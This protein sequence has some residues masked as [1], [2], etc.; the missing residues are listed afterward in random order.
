MTPEMRAKARGFMSMCKQM[1]ADGASYR[2]MEEMLENDVED[3]KT[4]GMA[5]SMGE[6]WGHQKQ[7]DDY[8]DLWSYGHL[9][10][11]VAINGAAE[12]LERALCKYDPEDE[13]Y[14]DF[15]SYG[16]LSDFKIDMN[17]PCSSY[18]HLEM[19]AEQWVLKWMEKNDVKKITTQ[20]AAETSTP[21]ERT[22]EEEACVETTQG[23]KIPTA[24]TTKDAPECDIVCPTCGQNDPYSE[25][26]DIENNRVYVEFMCDMC[27]ST[28][29][30]HYDLTGY[31][32]LKTG[33]NDEDGI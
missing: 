14:Y 32:E 9:E 31:V 15:P 2:M 20:Q 27:S 8:S 12:A 17:D 6:T 19:N 29:K 13:G 10:V 5:A 33:D 21:E 7:P 4:F 3:A 23:E 11:Y 30:C 1:D 22:V 24:G 16:L 28:W 18:A 25:E 26:V